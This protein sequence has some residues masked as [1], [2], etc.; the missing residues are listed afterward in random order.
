[1]QN[2]RELANQILRDI[3]D[4]NPYTQ[5]HKHLAFI[6]ATG[7]LARVIAEMIWRDSR[8]WEIYRV[9]RERSRA[10]KAPL[11]DRDKSPK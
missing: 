9:V 3:S 6:W 5:Q 4:L 7:F 11:L 2:V 1:M 10:A 8:N